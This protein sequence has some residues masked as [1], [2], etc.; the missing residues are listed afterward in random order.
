MELV[1]I[2]VIA[3]VVIA[4]MA[5]QVLIV[6]RKLTNATQPRVKMELHAEISS[7]VIPVIVKMVSKVKIAS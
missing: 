3:I 4:L 7:V 1:R 5:T 6:R 2:L